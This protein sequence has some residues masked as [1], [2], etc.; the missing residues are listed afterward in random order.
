MELCVHIEEL[1]SSIEELKCYDLKLWLYFVYCAAAVLLHCAAVLLY[2]CQLAL[3]ALQTMAVCSI[4]PNCFNPQFFPFLSLSP[5]YLLTMASALLSAMATATTA[6][7]DKQA[8]DFW[9]DT[10]KKQGNQWPAQ[11]NFQ[12]YFLLVL[13]LSTC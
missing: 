11:P 12:T 2:F 10:D 5:H 4:L 13:V 8:E 6:A 7:G 3:T 9:R 1:S